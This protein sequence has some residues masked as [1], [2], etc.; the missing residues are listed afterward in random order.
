V[1]KTF[2]KEGYGLSIARNYIGPH[3]YLFFTIKLGKEAST[4]E[5][6]RPSSGKATKKLR[7]SS[8]SNATSKYIT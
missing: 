8:Q 7:N 2:V 6:S 1:A 5:P 3:M 4:I